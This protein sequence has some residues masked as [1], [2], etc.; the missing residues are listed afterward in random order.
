[1]LFFIREKGTSY[2]LMKSP[3]R[4]LNLLNDDFKISLVY[5]C[6]RILLESRVACRIKDQYENPAQLV[7]LKDV[8]L[9]VAGSIRLWSTILLPIKFACWRTH[10]QLGTTIRVSEA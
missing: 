3:Y 9:R 6:S 1:M 8:D 10:L 2:C 7:E 4:T 5:P